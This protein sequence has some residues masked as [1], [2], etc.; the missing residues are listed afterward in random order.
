MWGSH[1]TGTPEQWQRPPEGI[2]SCLLS[3]SQQEGLSGRTKP[4]DTWAAGVWVEGA[5]E[6]VRLVSSSSKPQGF[7]RKALS[8]PKCSGR[9]SP[10]QRA[11]LNTEQR[12]P[13][14]VDSSLVLR[15]LLLHTACCQPQPCMCQLRTLGRRAS[16]QGSLPAPWLSGGL[17]R[18]A[19][20]LVERT[21]HYP[22]PRST[23]PPPFLGTRGLG[24]CQSSSSLGVE[25]ELP[26]GPTDGPIQAAQVQRARGWGGRRGRPATELMM[27]KIKRQ[28]S[29]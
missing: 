29:L 6:P 20:Q 28:T 14:S 2:C 25:V 12:V 8:H 17:I 22:P 23:P 18:A 16:G 3:S 19:A 10:L 21:R 1:T 26:H 13:P 11:P 5:L 4:G 9:V 7:G 15:E 27:T 24:G